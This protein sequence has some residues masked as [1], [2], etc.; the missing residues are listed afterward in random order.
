MFEDL[1]EVPVLRSKRRSKL[2]DN[3]DKFRQHSEDQFWS[4][5]SDIKTKIT[6][7]NAGT[8]VHDLGLHQQR[9]ASERLMGEYGELLRGHITRLRQIHLNLT[10]KKIEGMLAE[11]SSLP[12]IVEAFPM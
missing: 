9:I 1:L 11:R 8:I 5:Y 2:K 3:S 7:L 12:S 4:H 10:V 6:S